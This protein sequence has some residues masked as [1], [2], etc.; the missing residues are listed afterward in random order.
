M[1]SQPMTHQNIVIISPNG[2]NVPQTEKPMPTNQ[3]RNNLWGCLKSEIKTIGII[4]IMCGVMV[5]SLGILFVSAPYSSDFSDTIYLLLKTAHPFL[6]ALCFITSGSLCIIAERKTTKILIQCSLAFNIL[7]CL[8][9]IVGFVILS[10]KLA[11]LGTVSWRCHLNEKDKTTT[12]SYYYRQDSDAYCS[13]TTII[14]AGTLSLML[15]STL[16]EF[17]L[18]ALTAGMWWKQLQSGF[19]GSV[20]FLPDSHKNKFSSHTKVESSYEELLN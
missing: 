15:I 3:N 18:S 2:I 20:L 11:A 12:E 16:L 8:S 6:G 19:S 17:F 9:A 14:L 13:M 4:Q 10:I 7:S 5:L 1:L